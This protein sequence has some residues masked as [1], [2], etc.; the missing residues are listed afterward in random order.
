MSQ[1]LRKLTGSIAKSKTCVVFIN[2]MRMK[3]G[4]MFGNPE[5]TTGGQALKFYASV[6]LDIRR[7]GS[8]KKAEDSIGNRTRVRVVKNKLAPP[9]KEVEFDILYGGGISK[10][11]ELI[12]L[13]SDLGIV[14]K[15]GAWFG[16]NGD[17]IGQGRDNARQYLEEHKEV[18]TSIERKIR[19][20]FSLPGGAGPEAG[21]AAP[22]ENPSSPPDNVT[23]MPDKR[24]EKKSESK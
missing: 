14:E 3:I 23:P 10:T 22:S 12:D 20:H 21:A 13:G 17:R 6:R 24:R 7:V 2:Q 18:G 15:S 19:A 1:A 16:Y 8:I 5:T 4:V 11:G 9:F